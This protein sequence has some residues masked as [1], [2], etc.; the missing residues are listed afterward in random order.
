[1]GLWMT[2]LDVTQFGVLTRKVS[3]DET[4]EIPLLAKEA[5]SGAL[6]IRL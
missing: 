5:R 6:G 4:L 3:G 1:L 2:R